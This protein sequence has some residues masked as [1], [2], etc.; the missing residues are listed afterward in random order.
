MTSPTR[1]RT[2]RRWI[3]AATVLAT[4]TGA[5]LTA[6]GTASASDTPGSYTD[7]AFPGAAKG[8]SNVT[9]RTTVTKDPG[10]A[11]NVFWSHQFGFTK[12]NGAY[13]G[14]QANGPG[15]KRTFLFSVWDATEA[16]PGSKGSYCVDFGGEG[17]GKSC[18]IKYDWQQGHTYRT[19]VA[20][21]GNRWF[22]VTV[23]DET[24]GASFKLGS[25]RAASDRVSPDGMVDWTEYF[26]WND[27]RASCND[28]PYSQVRF[29]LPQGDDG[30]VTAKVSGTKA[31]SSCA[32]MSRID[33]TRDGSVQSNAIGNSVR[34]AVTGPGG[35]AV[36]AD[37]GTAL[38]RPPTGADNQQW[39][40]GKDKAL[41]LMTSG[42][43]LDVAESGTRNGTP[44]LAYDCN[45]GANQRWV[46]DGNGG[47]RNPASGRCLTAPSTAAGTPLQIR[48]CTGT[49]NQRWTVPATP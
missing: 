10:R 34:G 12:G 17:E 24:T 46:R 41:H 43:C 8:L 23:T 2:P 49:A 7:Y 28:Q 20:H 25:I 44:V 35:K 3:V 33:V 32:D 36:E 9:F 18:R 31:S 21:E 13:T 48:D 37:G 29:G 14:M 47:L 5:A 16:K 39:V 40:L 26:E 4:A 30:K 22:G 11:A 38:L 27:D 6:A 19:R 1:P 15:E 42:L 45:G